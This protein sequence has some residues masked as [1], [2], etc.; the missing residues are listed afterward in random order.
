MPP[1]DELR[2]D[3]IER[4]RENERDGDHGWAPTPGTSS[5]TGT[6]TATRCEGDEESNERKLGK[7]ENSRRQQWFGH[8]SPGLGRCGQK[9]VPMVH[10]RE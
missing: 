4:M 6:M 10:M 7:S 1:L 8:R 9:C 2:A 3:K 5:T